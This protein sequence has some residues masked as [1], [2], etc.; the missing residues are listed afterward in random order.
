MAACGYRGPAGR[1]A[2]ASLSWGL[3]PIFYDVHYK[4]KRLRRPYELGAALKPFSIGKPDAARRSGNDRSDVP[5]RPHRSLPPMARARPRSP[6]LRRRSAAA[7]CRGNRHKT[8]LRKNRHPSQRRR[9]SGGMHGTEPAVPGQRA[10]CAVPPR[11][12]RKPRLLSLR[13]R[14]ENRCASGSWPR[15]LPPQALPR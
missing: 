5:Y 9:A 15:P 7:S 1:I 3:R 8:A 12:I 13:F 6:A 14:E 2:F 4:R 10:R 11:A